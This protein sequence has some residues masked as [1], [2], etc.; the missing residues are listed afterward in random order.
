MNLL[1][2]TNLWLVNV[3]LQLVNTYVNHGLIR[4]NKFVLQISH[5]YTISFIIIS[6]LIFLIDT[7]MTE[8]KL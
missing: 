8:T 4:L 7:N 6:Y 1:N 2:L 5:G 3:M